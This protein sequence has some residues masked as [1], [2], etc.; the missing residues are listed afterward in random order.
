MNTVNQTL[1]QSLQIGP[2]G[3]TGVGITVTGPLVGINNLTDLVG[4]I[5]SFVVP[6]AGVIMFLVILWGGFDL[7]NSQGNPEKVQSGQQ[8][9]TAGVVGFVLLVLSYFAAKLIGYIFGV[10][11]G[12]L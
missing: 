7:V 1:A 4:L 5:I 2:P 6:L 8:K 3:T 9:M 12:I 11:D 10:G